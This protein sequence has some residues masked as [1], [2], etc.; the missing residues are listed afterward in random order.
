MAL[1]LSHVRRNASRRVWARCWRRLCF[2]INSRSNRL[3]GRGTQLVCFTDDTAACW[4]FH[5]P[6]SEVL[7][8]ESATARWPDSPRIH[9]V[10]PSNSPATNQTIPSSGRDRYHGPGPGRGRLQV[11]TC[12]R[13]VAQESKGTLDDDAGDINKGAYCSCTAT[14]RTTCAGRPSCYAL[15]SLHVPCPLAHLGRGSAYNS[16][17]HNNNNADHQGN[18]NNNADH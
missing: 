3:L 12:D 2:R 15:S 9:H 1:M 18:H 10:V 4:Q 13:R 5:L 8:Q 14:T 11:P 17:N 6:L 16:R 7:V